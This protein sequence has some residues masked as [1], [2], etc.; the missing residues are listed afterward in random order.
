MGRYW[1]EEITS[2]PFFKISFAIN[3]KGQTI[4]N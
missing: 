4:K 1:S 2:I 3:N